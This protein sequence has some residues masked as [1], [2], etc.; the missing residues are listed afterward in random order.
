MLAGRLRRPSREAVDLRRGKLRE[1]ARDVAQRERE[2]GVA[3]SLR[4]ALKELPADCLKATYEVS[5][6]LREARIELLL[7]SQSPDAL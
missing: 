5:D 7:G 4:R 3:I 2:T 6:A 1:F